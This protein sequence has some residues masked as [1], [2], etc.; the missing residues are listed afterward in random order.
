MRLPRVDLEEWSLVFKVPRS[1]IGFDKK[2]T[3]QVPRIPG[4]Q[5]FKG[6]STDPQWPRGQLSAPMC[7]RN[8][9]CS[10]IHSGHSPTVREP[11]LAQSQ[12]P[13]SRLEGRGRFHFS[14]INV[15]HPEPAL[16]THRHPQN[17]FIPTTNNTQQHPTYPTTTL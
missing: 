13:W 17:T 11:Q 1:L 10:A 4:F 7:A 2:S 6:R 12:F 15:N 14:S 3:S 5:N 8:L 9:T 16:G